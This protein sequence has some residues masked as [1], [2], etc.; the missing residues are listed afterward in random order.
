MTDCAASPTFP[1]LTCSTISADTAEH[2]DLCRIEF[3]F[4]SGGGSLG[5]GTDHIATTRLPT[6]VGSYGQ[7]TADWH[8]PPV[9]DQSVIVN[10]LQGVRQTSIAH[11][12]TVLNPSGSE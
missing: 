7:T 11:S 1:A 6:C 4:L 10:G 3:A 8:G 5:I 2:P 9:A 12:P